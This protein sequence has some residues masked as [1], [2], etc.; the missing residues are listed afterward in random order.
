MITIKREL[1]KRSHG[2]NIPGVL[3]KIFFLKTH[4]MDA[5]PELVKA[6]VSLACAS[7][8]TL[9]WKIQEG[10]KGTLVQLVWSGKQ[11]GKEERWSE[12][13]EERWSEKQEERPSGSGLVGCVVRR[14]VSPSRARRNARRR[15]A[16]LEKQAAQKEGLSVGVCVGKVEEEVVGGQTGNVHAEER[17]EHVV[18]GDG[19]VGGGGG[20]VSGDDD[21][22]CDDVVSSEENGVSS[23]GEEVVDLA[24]CSRAVDEKRVGEHGVRFGVDGFGEGWTPV[25]R[26]QKRKWDLEI[27]GG[28][29][30]PEEARVELQG[31]LGL[32]VQEGRVR[33]W[34]PISTRTR[35]RFK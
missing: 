26:R 9:S 24:G 5:L 21:G 34:D 8:R 13:Q 33:W 12:K 35:N 17:A 23:D 14:R 7:G 29:R 27:G 2:Y 11:K 1:C 22:V 15:Q 20:G 10:E 6:T 18:G 32:Q 3:I 16:F 25:G 31:R 19:G 28:L 30:V 4:N